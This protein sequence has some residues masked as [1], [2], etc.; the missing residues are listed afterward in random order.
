M[1]VPT[2]SA[3]TLSVNPESM[4]TA[5]TLLMT[6][7][8]SADTMTSRPRIMSPTSVTTGSTCLRFPTNTKKH[9]NVASRL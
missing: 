2:S 6:W 8:A 5:G 1:L 9:T 4:I 3:R 7:L